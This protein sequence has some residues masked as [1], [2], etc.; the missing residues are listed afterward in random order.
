MPLPVAL[1]LV[2]EA[3]FGVLLRSEKS[4]NV[5]KNSVR[6]PSRQLQP[7]ATLGNSMNATGTASVSQTPLAD[8]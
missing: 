3:R 2:R 8:K 7:V 4:R 5:D 1:E 6:E